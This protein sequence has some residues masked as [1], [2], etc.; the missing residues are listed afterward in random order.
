MIFEQLKKGDKEMRQSEL[1]ELGWPKN[2]IKEMKLE[3]YGLP[4]DPVEFG[5]LL[6]SVIT[7][8]EYRAINWH[9]ASFDTYDTIAG[10]LGVTRERVRQIV[11]KGQ[12]RFKWHIFTLR[13]AEI[14]ALKKAEKEA[15]LAAG[16]DIRDMEFKDW[17]EIVYPS[18][19]FLE[20]RIRNGILRDF[21]YN[22]WKANGYPR[23]EHREAIFPTIT[24]KTVVE[25][26]KTGEIY[27]VRNLGAKSINRLIEMLLEAGITKEEMGL[28]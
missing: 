25:I 12:H 5:E 14:D 21:G 22:Q 28:E 3:N 20:V 7:P 17:F 10:W 24:V 27:K 18:P 13:K 2:V 26:I 15:E 6:A 9:Y 4:D 1:R 23:D 11:I 16:K 8:R 19:D